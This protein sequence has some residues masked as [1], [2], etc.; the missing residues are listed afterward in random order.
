MPQPPVT[1]S[2]YAFAAPSQY[3]NPNLPYQY[4]QYPPGYY[5]SQPVP[6]GPVPHNFHRYPC[7]V[8]PPMVSPPVEHQKAVTIR[9]DVNIRKDSIRVEEDDENPGKF[10]IAFTFDATAPGR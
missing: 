6:F 3:P 2:Q 8:A 4:H 10:L 1:A 9:N 5:P 7:G